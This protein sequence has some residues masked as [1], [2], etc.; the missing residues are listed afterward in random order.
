MFDVSN[1]IELIVTHVPILKKK[2]NADI[3][4]LIKPTKRCKKEKVKFV[5]TIT[6]A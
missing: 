6:Q 2:L 4:V 3:I 5:D 1:C